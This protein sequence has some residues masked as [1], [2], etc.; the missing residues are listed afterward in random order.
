MALGLDSVLA[1]YYWIQAVLL[2]GGREDATR[3]SKQLGRLIDVVT[4][5]D[6]WVGHPYRFAA[7][8]LTDTQDD[9]RHANHL[10][11]RSFA[12]HPDE[13]RNRFYL[14]FNLFYYLDDNES[15]AEVLWDA[16]Q[17]S[18]SPLYLPRL[19]ARLRSENG[20][21]EAAAVFLQELVRNAP[22]G[23]SRAEYQSALDEIEVEWRAR[24]L[25]Q[26]RSAYQERW[27]RDI[28]RVEQLAVGPDA[29]L[30]RLPPAEPSSLPLPLRKGS[31]WTIDE[32]TGEIESSYY[33][34]RYRLHG[35]AMRARSRAR[36]Q[37]SNSAQGPAEAAGDSATPAKPPAS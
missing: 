9:V 4:T 12:Y 20:G 28:D 34:K 2:A 7:I 10:L 33:D 24:T 32:E 35:E 31:G 5:L 13:W 19:V 17:L 6:P 11:R 22:N 23:A 26:A 27:G 30:P 3:H 1:D 29:I 21:L 8:W 15:A 18:G 36:Q 16:S 25:D 14:G 37:R